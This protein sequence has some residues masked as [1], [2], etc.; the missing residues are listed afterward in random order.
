VDYLDISGNPSTST[1]SWYYIRVWQIT[2]VVANMKQITVTT[3]VRNQVGAPAGALPQ[4]TLVTL[5]SFP[6]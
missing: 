6:F 3:K 1:G 5:K 2:Q 4:T